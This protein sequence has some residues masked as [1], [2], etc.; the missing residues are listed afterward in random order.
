MLVIVGASFVSATTNVKVSVA[1][2]PAA[3]VTVTVTLWLPTSSFTGVPESVAVP[4]PLSVMLRKDVPVP[5]SQVSQAKV[6]AL[7][8]PE[9]ISAVVIE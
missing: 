7:V 6:I 4:S 5:S 9:S 1:V 8:S 3:S 2:A